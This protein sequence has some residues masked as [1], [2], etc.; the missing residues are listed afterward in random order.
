MDSGTIISILGV[1]LFVGG[2]LAILALIGKT[3]E[4]KELKQNIDKLM[5]S[6]H[7]LDEQAKIIVKTDLELNKTQEELDKRLNDLNTLQKAS[8]LIST[9][10]DKDEIF[11]RLE[12]PLFSDLGYERNIIFLYDKDRI[13]HCRISAG[14]SPQEIIHIVASVSNDQN[15]SSALREGQA[16]SSAMSAEKTAEKIN[17]LFGVEHFILSPVLSQDGVIGIIFVGNRSDAAPVTESDMELLSILAN[18]IGQSLENAQLF[19]Q[20]YHSRQDLESTVQ[21]RTKQLAS[22]LEE[23]KRISKIKSEFISAVSHELRTPL[24]SIKGYASI[25]MTGKIGDIP[26]EVKDR[27]E[28]INKHSDNLVKLINDL[29]DISRIESGRIEMNYVRTKPAAMIESVRD[30]LTPQMKDKEIQF[31]ANVPPDM[32]DFFVD[33]NQVERVFINLVGNA[34]KFTPAQGKITV[35]AMKEK[36]ILHFSVTDTGIG[37]TEDELAKLFE[38]FY[39]VENEINQNVKGTGLGLALAKKI[40]EAHKGKIWVE[41]AFGKGTTFHFTIPIGQETIKTSKIRKPGEPPRLSG[42]QDTNQPNPDGPENK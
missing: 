30:L 6:F 3:D 41:S 35:K 37:I 9:T 1:L 19:E 14:F 34:I 18:Q 36:D 31:I 23:V 42:F 15:L 16:F 4:I 5:R 28:K 38:E 24:T 40:V 25:L 20:V 27:L 29:L 11:N 12:Q 10:L 21:D 26:P 2:G 8:R 32:P 17:H 33:N 7:E 13:L 22:A 39:R